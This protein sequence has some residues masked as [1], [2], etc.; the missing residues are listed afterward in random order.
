ML[1]ARRALACAI[2]SL[3]LAAHTAAAATPDLSGEESTGA[4]FGTDH[5]PQ[6]KLWFNDGA[7][8]GVFSDGGGQRIWKLDN[9]TLVRELTGDALVDSRTSSRCDVLWDGTH[10]YV[11]V[12]HTT[13]PR[14]VKYSYDSPTQTYHRLPGFPIDLPFPGLECMVLDKDSTGRL[15]IAFEMDHVIRAIWST[16]PDHLSWDFTGTVLETNVGSD[17]IATVV[18]FGGD[19]IGVLWSDQSSDAPWQFGFRAHRDSDPPDVWQPLEVVDTGSQVDDHINVKADTD[20]RLWFAG[21]TLSNKIH[22]Y[23]RSAAGGWSRA[24]SDIN[25]GTCTRPT[26]LLDDA[27]DLIHVFYTDWETSPNPIRHVSAPRSTGIFSLPEDYLTPTGTS[28]LNDPTTTKQ[29]ALAGA[30][31]FVIAA[32]PSRVRWGFTSLDTDAPTAIALDPADNTAGVPLQPLVQWRVSDAGMGV[33]RSSIALTVDG[34]AATPTLAGDAHEYLV[35]WTP[36]AAYA[37][38]HIVNMTLTA[39]D[40]AYPP[41]T[42]TKTARFKTEMDPLAMDLKYDFQPASSPTAP[43]YVAEAGDDYTLERGFGWD[44]SVTM[45]DA[46]VHSDPKLDTYV[47]RRNNNS[48]ATWSHDVANGVYRISFA[49]GAPEVGGKQR[50]EVEGQLLINNQTTAAGQ[51]ITVT[52]YELTVQDGRLDVTIGGAGSSSN[53]TQLPYFEFEYQGAAPP[54]PPPNAPAPLPVGGLT[55]AVSGSD[56]NLAWNA[57]THDTTGTLI[58]VSRYNIYRGTNP[59]FVPDRANHTNRVATAI[60]TS[61]RDTGAANAS[62]DYYYIVTAERSGG[63]ESRLPSNLGLRRRIQVA[64]PAAGNTRT[65]W[66]AMPY[67]TAF[68][69]ASDLVLN[70]NGSA[71]SGPV[72]R[73]ARVDRTTQVR[74]EWSRTGGVWSGQDFALVPGEAVEVTVGA[75]LD[76]RLVGAESSAPSYGFAFHTAVGNVNWIALPQNSDYADAQSLVQAL[77]GGSGAGPVTKLTWYDPASGQPA[78]YLWF[79]GEWRGNNFPLQVGWGVAVLVGADVPVW[80]PRRVTQ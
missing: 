72:T 39:Q 13:L 30:G 44:R 75:A 70:M 3:C 66:L 40:G 79:A 55:V 60:A 27:Q 58:A 47:H 29:H 32:A 16:S 46:G 10:L 50:I 65:V 24:F 23:V 49:A 11:L 48:K 62:T 5:K 9:G 61:W 64:A 67:A 7:W 35:S 76:W 6:S 26:I 2:A 21:K 51:F 19:K 69:D 80:S 45:K 73:V 25:R 37:P 36:P 57:V 71:T 38:G 1:R 34:I 77:N 43:G 17:D 78:S 59:R 56:L 18:A 4:G 12:F 53:Y 14:L 33:R 42:V 28:S 54:P 8:W 20:G 63:I 41:H 74:S 68:A 31:L 52:G 15:W 22:V